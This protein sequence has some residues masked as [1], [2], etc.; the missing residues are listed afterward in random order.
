MTGIIPA[1]QSN[2][3][4]LRV[5]ESLAKM[6]NIDF[7]SFVYGYKFYD[8]E[9]YLLKALSPSQSS[10]EYNPVRGLDSTVPTSNLMDKSDLFA[11]TGVGL[12]FTRATYTSTTGAL[13]AYGNF[14]I[15]TYPY[16]SV[17]SGSNE[18]AGLLNIVNGTVS[19]S[20]NADQQWNIPARR[21]VYADEYVQSQVSTI[22]YGGT[23]GQQGILNLN[24]IVVLD[25]ENQNNVTV[26]LPA[27]GTL[28]NID[29]NTNASTR[30]L[31]GVRLIGF[32]IRNLAGGA[33]GQGFAAANCRV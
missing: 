17:F 16:V 2:S 8:D 24:S 19:L 33:G 20:V 3:N 4:Y 15:Y 14:P 6:L 9:L 11:V 29:G 12:V 5:G 23:D 18:Q 22:V 32:R 10:Y 31:L 1:T 26:T 13:S 27:G 7:K 30:N 25:G 28:T 21:M